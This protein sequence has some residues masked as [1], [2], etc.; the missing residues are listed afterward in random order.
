[1]MNNLNTNGKDD[2]MF[3]ELSDYRQML[4]K[5]CAVSTTQIKHDK[6]SKKNIVISYFFAPSE[7]KHGSGVP[8]YEA[9][10]EST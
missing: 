5:P 3:L 4:N 2:F 8:L 6:T 10:Q 7:I 9:N 1:M